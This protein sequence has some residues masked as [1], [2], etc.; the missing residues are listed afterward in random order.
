MNYREEIEKMIAEVIENTDASATG[1]IISPWGIENLVIHFEKELYYGR[2]VTENRI[3]E[4]ML[5]EEST[6]GHLVKAKDILAVLT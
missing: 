3:E 4:R 2:E 6:H 5:I 1:M